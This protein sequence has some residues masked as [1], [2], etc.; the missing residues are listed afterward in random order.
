MAKLDENPLQYVLLSLVD[1]LEIDSEESREREKE[2]VKQIPPALYSLV[3][4]ALPISQG[5]VL[6]GP[7]STPQYAGSQFTSSFQTPDHNRNISD[8]S[9]GTRST[10]T[11]LTKLDQPGAK[12]QS[13][14]KKFVDAIITKLWL[15]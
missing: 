2:K 9:F 8:T 14:Q 5:S 6:R 11:T 4:A 12:V 7:A 15:G 3:S 13:L 10:D 1:L